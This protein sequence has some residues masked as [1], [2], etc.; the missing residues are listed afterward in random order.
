VK[1]GKDEKERKQ[2]WM[3]NIVWFKKKKE[4]LIV[5][6][7]SPEKSYHPELGRKCGGKETI[8]VFYLIWPSNNIN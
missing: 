1:S 8:Q 3:D 2:K 5:Y 7:P 6:H 4:D